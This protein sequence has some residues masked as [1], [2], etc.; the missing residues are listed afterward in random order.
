MKTMKYFWMLCIA[1]I[2]MGLTS[3]KDDDD[4]GSQS[5]AMRIDKVFLQD[6]KSSV[7]DREVDFARLG[8]LIRIQGEGFKGL[9]KIYI[10]GYDT[11][12]NNAL[13]TDN[14]VWVT[15]NGNTPV[16]TAE[17]SVRNTITF[18]KDNTSTTYNFTIRAAAPSITSFDNSLP[19]A[20][21]T[22]TVY[23][24]NLQET[25]SVTLPGGVV[26]TD[27]IV[28]D[29]EGKWFTFVMPDGVTEGGSLI[30]EGANGTA[31]S[32]AYFNDFSCFI[33]DFDGKGVLGAWSATYGTD[34]LVDDP[35]GTGRGKVA[36]LIPASEYDEEG[37]YPAG[38]RTLLWATAGN[39]EPTDDWNRMTEFIPAN[40]SV[41]DLAIQFDLYVDGTW[42]NTGQFEISLQNN[43]STYGYGSGDTKPSTQYLHQA[44][45]WIP[46]LNTENGESTHYTTGERWVTVTIPMNTIG[47]YSD[48]EVE[49]TFQNVIDDRN[50]GSYRNL[51]FF[52]VNTDIELS[53]D[54]VVASQPTNIKLY[55]DN[56][57]VVNTTAETVSDFP[58]E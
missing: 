23:G 55:I 32:P 4:S 29:E 34:E 25:V 52:F 38:K 49:Y 16:E 50:A 46:W 43:L 2:S 19:K 56:L 26:V 45:V 47:N 48:G 13:L 57:R 17:A 21:E 39:D 58:E 30:S 35:L 20:G 37:F 15:L 41:N 28:N 27:G 12:F 40:T 36:M 10:N 54:Q 7:P 24:N 8:Q 14:N 3:C 1:L 42:E 33:I 6:V 18:V 11:Y 53:D 22:V 9:K 5:K 31:K 51:L 44:G